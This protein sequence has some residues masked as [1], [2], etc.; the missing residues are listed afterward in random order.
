[1]KKKIK[2]TIE[3]SQTELEQLQSYIEHREQEGW[4]WLPQDQF[5]KRHDRLR[6]LFQMDERPNEGKD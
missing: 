6:K 3:L 1:M 2:L 5:E 4:Y